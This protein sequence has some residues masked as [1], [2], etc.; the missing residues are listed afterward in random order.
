LME[1]LCQIRHLSSATLPH[2]VGSLV[3][4]Q[5]IGTCTVCVGK[6][7]KKTNADITLIFHVIKKMNGRQTK[8]IFCR[9][10]IC[11]NVHTYVCKWQDVVL[12]VYVFPSWSNI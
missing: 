2:M 1:L 4:I 8:T 5:Y 12:A 10:R 3:G 11:K 6:I 9:M 7:T